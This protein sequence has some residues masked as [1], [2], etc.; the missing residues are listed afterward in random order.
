MIMIHNKE[1]NSRRIRGCVCPP[2]E[3]GDASLVTKE[4]AIGELDV[5]VLS[6][7]VEGNFDE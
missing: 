2:V 3:L 1:K 6:A 4:I 5:G 7:L